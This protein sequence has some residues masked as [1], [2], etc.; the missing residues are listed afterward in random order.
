[1][2]LTWQCP[3]CYAQLGDRSYARMLTCPYCGSLLIV[4]PEE[5]KFYRVPKGKG[6]YYFSKIDSPGYIKF[7]EY[8]E[9]YKYERESWYLLK[10]GDIYQLQGEFPLEGE[11]MEEGEVSFIWGEIPFV[12]P[13]GSIL[14]TAKSKN[15][16]YKIA[17]RITLLFL[18]SEK[19]VSDIF[20]EIIE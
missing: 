7:G 6:W 4:N 5:K 18:K 10:D 1:M 12:A 16:I 19:K 14:K 11:I 17:S 15:K 9:H 3:T 13:P 2:R 20:S 8:E